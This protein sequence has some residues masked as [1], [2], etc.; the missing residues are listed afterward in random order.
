[1]VAGENDSIDDANKLSELL[2]GFP[3]HVNLIP[4]NQIKERNYKRSDRNRVARFKEHLEKNGI[5]A[6]VRRSMG[7][8]IDAAC[9]QLRK[10]YIE[11]M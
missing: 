2:R 5:N 7:K 11:R 1:M 10:A 6:T 9:G 4:V 3:C 8:D